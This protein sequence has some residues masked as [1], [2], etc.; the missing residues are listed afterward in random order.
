MTSKEIQV[1][2]FLS[3]CIIF[4]LGAA[5]GSYSAQQGAKDATLIL[6][7]NLSM[8]ERTLITNSGLCHYSQLVCMKEKSNAQRR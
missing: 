7:T 1:L 3:L 6:W 8:D 4:M 5:A 2:Y